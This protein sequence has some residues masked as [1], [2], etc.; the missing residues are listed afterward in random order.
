MRLKTNGLLRNVRLLDIE[1]ELL[2]EAFVV[3][4]QFDAE[5]GD[6]L[7]QFFLL[8]DDG[9]VRAGGDFIDKLL[10]IPPALEKIRLQTLPFGDACA[11]QI[12]QSVLQRLG[13]QLLDV[14]AVVGG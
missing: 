2:G 11:V 10:E 7:L 6:A 9:V 12:V 14:F 8:D 5:R 4:L 3:G 13:G 1:S